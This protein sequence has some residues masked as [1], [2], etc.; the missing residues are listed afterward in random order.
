MK[1]RSYLSIIGSGV[2]AGL[3]G[4]VEPI[5]DI[6]RG[7]ES[8]VTRARDGI[9]DRPPIGTGKIDNPNS[10]NVPPQDDW[11]EDYLGENLDPFDD[12]SFTT[13]RSDRADPGI[14]SLSDS[15]YNNEFVAEKI[16]REI[17]ESDLFSRDLN[18][19][20]SNRSALLVESGYVS[21]NLRHKW[22]AL[23]RVRNN[24]YRLYGYYRMPKNRNG[25]LAKI[26]SV[27]AL[28]SDNNYMVT[29]TVNQDTLINFRPSDGI[30]GFDLL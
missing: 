9:I 5:R 4:C 21:S 18:L 12:L 27:I 3:S 17:R 25:N 30:V 10:V 22:M 8:N 2:S 19:D 1:R 23:E 15:V 16:D 20:Y 24:F 13:I 26:S 14:L 6:A 29:L 11:N 28:P 7:N